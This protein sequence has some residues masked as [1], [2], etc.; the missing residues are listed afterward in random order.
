MPH[1]IFLPAARAEYEHAL[2]WYH[3]RSPVAANDFEAAVESAVAEIV[4][5]PDR[6]AKVG[7][8]H[9]RYLVDGFPSCI[10]PMPMRSSWLQ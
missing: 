9:R 6:W 7:I 5:S 3:E 10:V 8:T 4:A 2:E 1:V